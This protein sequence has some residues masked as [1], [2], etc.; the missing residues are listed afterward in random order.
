MW[1]KQ[2]VE[3]TENGTIFKRTLRGKEQW[4]AEYTLGY[5]DEGKRKFKTIYGKTRKEV[6]E[7][8]DLLISELKTDTY[9]DKSKMIFK[10]LCKQFIDD[11][12]RL[13]KLNE[14]S[15]KRKMGTYKEI[16]GHYMASMEIQQINEKNIKDFLEYIT[17]YSNSVIGKIYGLVNTTFKRAIRKNIIKYNILDDKLEFGKPKSNKKD[18]KV[19]GFTVE[20]QQKCIKALLS[21]ENH[22]KYRYQFLLSMF[23]G[24][25]M[26]EINALDVDKDIDYIHKIIH[27]RRTLTRDKNDKTIMGD[28]T[29]TKNGVRDIVMDS[30]IEYILK[31]YM[32]T[33]Y[34]DNDERLLFYNPKYT[35][36]STGQVNMVFKRFCEYFKI[37]KCYDV[38]QHQLRHTFATRCIESRNACKCII[39]N[40]GACGHTYYVRSIL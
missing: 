31:Q 24:M 38:N 40:N 35:Y 33:E 11:S 18:K 30:Q 12:F 17:K 2:K 4:V 16:C 10:D 37:N 14:A 32:K 7:K 21:E 25:R 1:E 29:K 27:V 36:Y 6:K 39:K 3:E 28:Y 19:S 9:V 22:F 5:T 23:T 13:N 8:L 20:E 15:Y 26:G 34:I